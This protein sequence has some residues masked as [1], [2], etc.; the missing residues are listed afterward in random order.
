MDFSASLYL[1]FPLKSNGPE[2]PDGETSKAFGQPD[3]V[4]LR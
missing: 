1:D 2:T 4:A 3:Q